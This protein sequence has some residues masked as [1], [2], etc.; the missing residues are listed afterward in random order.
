MQIIVYR[1]CVI[2]G[3]GALPFAGRFGATEV[4][5]QEGGENGNKD[6]GLLS[7]LAKYL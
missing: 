6:I 4:L 5:K 3:L 7:S 1:G 2:W